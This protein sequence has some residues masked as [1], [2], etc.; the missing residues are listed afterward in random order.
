MCFPA[1]IIIESN[2]NLNSPSFFIKIFLTPYNI[3]YMNSRN[4]P[5][6]TY[7]NNLIEKLEFN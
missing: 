5:C 2:T 3:I 1:R 6:K 4:K 7:K